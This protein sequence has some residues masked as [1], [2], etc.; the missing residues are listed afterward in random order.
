MIT[1]LGCHYCTV[2]HLLNGAIPTLL[3]LAFQPQ[4]FIL[5]P[6]I[7]YPWKTKVPENFKEGARKEIL[8]FSSKNEWINPEVLSGMA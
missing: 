2:L 3:C 7:I 1:E 6:C 4:V 8:F 5:P